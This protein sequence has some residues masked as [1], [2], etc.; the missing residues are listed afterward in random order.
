VN[1]LSGIEDLVDLDSPEN[2]QSDQPK[3][4]C[5]SYISVMHSNID[6]NI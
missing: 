4:M 5:H 6:D 1:E 2:Q 3:Q